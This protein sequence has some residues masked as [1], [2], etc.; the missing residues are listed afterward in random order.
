MAQRF[1][2]LLSWNVPWRVPTEFCVD[3]D[4]SNAK[5]TE[6]SSQLTPAHRKEDLVSEPRDVPQVVREY[7]AKQGRKGGKK[8]GRIRAT[9][10][11]PEERSQFARTAADARW[12]KKRGV[13]TNK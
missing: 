6:V 5:H 12:A 4:S 3:H 1:H 8:G 11:T 2:T 9:R 10:L 13:D 7:L